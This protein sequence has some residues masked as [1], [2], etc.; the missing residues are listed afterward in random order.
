MPAR[1]AMRGSSAGR[2][3]LPVLAPSGSACETGAAAASLT[4]TSSLRARGGLAAFAEVA[5]AVRT[6]AATSRR[7]RATLRFM[8]RGRRRGEREPRGPSWRR[9]DAASLNGG[10]RAARVRGRGSVCRQ[11]S[12]SCCILRIRRTPG[13][14]EGPRRPGSLAQTRCGFVAALIMRCLPSF[15]SVGLGQRAAAAPSTSRALQH[16]CWL[17]DCASRRSSRFGRPTRAEKRREACRC[18]RRGGGRCAN[19]GHSSQVDLGHQ[20]LACWIKEADRE[21][22]RITG[23]REPPPPAGPAGLTDQQRNQHTRSQPRQNTRA[24]R[25]PTAHQAYQAHHQAVRLQQRSQRALTCWGSPCGC[26]R[27]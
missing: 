11:R 25:A 16:R 27:A 17:P 12:I 18:C 26:R 5:D 6:S 15:D 10:R 23:R 22:R 19:K 2:S 13:C 21:R 24:P 3:G 1:G 4:V 20:F 9:R 8:V 7:C 14:Y